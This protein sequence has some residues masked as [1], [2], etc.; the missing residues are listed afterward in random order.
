MF[1]TDMPQG[2][3][4]S[5]FFCPSPLRQTRFL[6]PPVS[7]SSRFSTRTCLQQLGS[8]SDCFPPPPPPPF[9]CFPSSLPNVG[10]GINSPGAV[11]GYSAVVFLRDEASMERR[12][13]VRRSERDK[14]GGKK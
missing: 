13:A 11:L 1:R 5:S 4:V 2:K 9:L 10:S 8:L 3:P 6:P 12:G 14:E 7:E